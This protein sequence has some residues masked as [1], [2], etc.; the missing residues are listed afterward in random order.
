MA[1]AAAVISLWYFRPRSLA[2][3]Y[4]NA[5]SGVHGVLSR[6]CWIFSLCMLVMNTSRMIESCCVPKSHLCASSV[7]T[8]WNCSIVSSRFCFRVN[9]ANLSRVMLRWRLKQVSQF[10]QKVLNVDFWHTHV[11]NLCVKSLCPSDPKESQMELTHF[12][13]ATSHSSWPVAVFMYAPTS[14][15]FSHLAS[16]ASLRSPLHLKVWPWRPVANGQTNEQVQFL[17]HQ[18]TWRCETLYKRC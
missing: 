4:S 8:Q 18:R 9:N 5:V 3:A 12:L 6:S 1:F 17:T 13:T 11:G 2:I 10:F 16:H 14:W 7:R 15:S